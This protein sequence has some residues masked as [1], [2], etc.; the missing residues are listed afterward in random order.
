MTFEVTRPELPEPFPVTF[1]VTRP[2]EFPEPFP[3]TFEVTRPGLP[4]PFP[5]TFEVTR[6]AVPLAQ[7]RAAL[8]ACD[9]AAIEQYI[10]VLS[11][12]AASFGEEGQSLLGEL[13]R[14]VQGRVAFGRAQSR[15][16]AGD[17]QAAR[18]PLDE[19][20]ESQC[21]AEEV[22]ALEAEIARIVA[23]AKQADRALAACTGAELA[24]ARTA[25]GEE[26]HVT[27]ADKR[28]AL[29]SVIAARNDAEGAYNEAKSQYEAGDLGLAATSMNAAQAALDRVRQ[30]AHCADLGD[31]IAILERKIRSMP[32][33]S[34]TIAAINSCDFEKAA[35]L[36]AQIPEG[37]RK[38]AVQKAYD[39]ARKGDE[40]ARSLFKSAK[41]QYKACDYDATITTLNRAIDENPC[42]EYREFLIKKIAKTEKARDLHDKARSLY[43][44]AQGLYRT[45]MYK[46]DL[47]NVLSKLNAA[48]NST[49]CSEYR[50]FLNEKKDKVNQALGLQG[51]AESKFQEAQGLYK[52][53][54]F[55]ETISKLND[56]MSTPEPRCREYQVFLEKKKAKAEK[57]RELYNKAKS[58]FQ[59]AKILYRQDD[60]ENSVANLRQ[61]FRLAV[62]CERL[63][64]EIGQMIA[65][66][67]GKRKPSPEEQVAAL[68][69][70]R[71]GEAEAYWN[72][73]EK[74]ARCK[75]KSGYK[76]SGNT[77]VPTRETLVQNLDCRAYPNT[78]AAWDDRNNRPACFCINKNYKWRRDGKGCIPKSGGVIQPNPM[79]PAA[80]YAIKNK[81]R[82]GDNTG[83]TLLATNAKSMGCTDPV[84]DQVLSGGGTGGGG[85]GGGGTGDCSQCSVYENWLKK[86]ARACGY[87]GNRLPSICD[88]DP[89]CIRWNKEC[90]RVKK[91]LRECLAQCQNR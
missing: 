12:Q 41:G 30:T 55:D 78:Y 34:D 14:E 15:F 58:L 79:C 64:D 40:K 53:C 16:E 68:D 49:M 21:L 25:I 52:S 23:L 90:N 88:L 4:E 69:C 7:A 86:N 80:V 89:E 45:C 51:A 36:I 56:T 24:L 6:P 87:H 3:V 48:Q 27:L 72:E 73:S 59:E 44:E 35:E 75:C 29:D 32:L 43:E 57:A 22:A 81:L 91:Q 42:D 13:R 20:S 70:S 66:V 74:R 18:S 26:P 76:P 5:V 38:T 65:K 19:A 2:E 63:Q 47:N 10:E 85:Q 31:K 77:C 83:L 28:T 9:F 37:P 67:K 82:S 61:A 46:E 39:K 60:Y 54:K 8:E 50:D 84:I 33:V 11:S 62:V 71:Y 17:L 1:K